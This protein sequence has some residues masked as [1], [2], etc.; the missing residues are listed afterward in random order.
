M[1]G[2][3]FVDENFC[4]KMKTLSFIS[5]LIYNKYVKEFCMS[6][7]K[8][9]VTI[10]E[11]AKTAGVSLATVSRVINHHP[12][13][14]E[15]TRMQVEN[16]IN[17][18]G[19]KPSALAQGLAT[20]RSTNIGILIPSV[21]YVY[22][23]NMLAGMADIASI[24]GFQSILF[25][26]QHLKDEAKDV[27]EKLITSHVDGAVI[28]DDQLEE[29][30]IKTLQQ[31]NIPFVTFNHTTEG[32]RSLSIVLDY[33]STMIDLLENHYESK[34][35]HHVKFLNTDESGLMM[36]NLQQS[37]S[38]CCKKHNDEL[39]IISAHDSYHHLYNQMLEYFEKHKD[40]GYFICPRDSQACAVLNAAIEKGLKV[41]QQVEIISVVGTKY[42][43]IVRPQISSLDIDMFEVGSIAMRLLT[44]I[45][46][47][48]ELSTKVYRKKSTYTS[49]GSTI[50]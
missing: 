4:L 18:L 22:I 28:F 35:P 25:I 10:Y 31:F 34:N 37:I 2:A 13:V 21:N 30:D 48:E 19:Y 7:F 17:K 9:R 39:E 47:E 49:R 40:G 46:A 50:D 14:T 5:I 43:Y 33:E 29:S 23:A 20:N 11:V 8:D 38:Q 15:K 42:S 26:T 12:N 1:H 41:P 6:Q 16:A 36:D 45:L 27:F 24:Y 44:K 3:F 32:P